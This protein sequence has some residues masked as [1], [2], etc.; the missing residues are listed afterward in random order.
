[1]NITK[2]P[3]GSYRIRHMVDGKTY[4]VTVKE[5]PS[6]TEA[7]KLITAKINKPIMSSNMTVEMACKAY[8]DAKANVLS[9]TTYKEYVGTAKRLPD[10]FKSM[11]IINVTSL[12]VQK[13]VNDYAARLSP[14]T[15]ANYA[16]FIF[17]VLKAQEI[18]IKFPKLPQRVKST[19]YIPSV[20][21]IQKVF[22]VIKGSEHE[23]AIIL[24]CYG[25]RRS[26][27]CA[28]TLDDLD[29]NKLTINK[30]K[31]KDVNNQWVIK[32]TKTVDSTRTIIIPDELADRIREKGYIYKYIPGSICRAL[33]R[34]E[35]QAGVPT[36]PL[37]KLRHFF[38]SYLFEKGYNSKQIQEM[39]GW[40][41]DNV[42]RVV[43][44][45]AMNMDLAKRQMAYHIFDIVSFVFGSDDS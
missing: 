44:L 43:Y 8:I 42:M 32:T 16:N 3:S 7:M 1:M 24:C 22:K 5:K 31:V 15:V 6:K 39:G 25:L 30:A 13:V 34:A 38:A 40:R 35:K 26:E 20:E 28:L 10:S 14:K 45:H 36:F 4:S 37:H 27:V 19:P 29:G 17:S 12:D 18:D 33:E 11:K 9:P 23:I 2:L 21:D 41:T